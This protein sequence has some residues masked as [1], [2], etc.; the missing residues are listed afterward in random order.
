M[1]K[2]ARWILLVMLLLA[3]GFGFVKYRGRHQPVARWEL[4]DGT[5][6]R[7]E[8]L[9]Y[10][11]KHRIP[12]VG[13]LG[14]WSSQ[15][16]NRWLHLRLP[17]YQAEYRVE[18]T[19]FPCPVLW[20]TLLDPQTGKLSQPNI[21]GVAVLAEPG[22]IRLKSLNG[23]SSS[24]NLPFPC[25]AFRI[26]AY[27]RRAESIRLRLD[28]GGQIIE[29]NITNPARGQSFVEWKPEPLP[30]TR[31]VGTREFTLKELKLFRW[32]EGTQKGLVQ[33]SSTFDI[34]DASG[35]VSGG[36]NVGRDLLD[37]T[38]NMHLEILP[39]DE[40]AWKVRAS[41]RRN[42]DCPFAASEG[43]TLG[44]VEMPGTDA[45]AEFEV[46]VD[47]KKNGIRFAAIVGAG[48]FIWEDGKFLNAEAVAALWDKS[49]GG[50]GPG[51]H[52]RFSQSFSEPGLM[53]LLEGTD[54][55][56]WVKAENHIA[57]R[58]HT[59]GKGY[60]LGSGGGSASTDG[61]GVRRI[62]RVFTAPRDERGNRVPLS[63]PVSIQIVPVEAEVVEFLVAPPKLPESSP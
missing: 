15:M 32:K 35:D 61:N 5:E 14:A 62:K 56:K 17:Y 63:G 58:L 44:P 53:L 50:F 28:M 24:G 43:L 12:G 47:E 18:D 40:P 21:T 4:A 22:A 38:G 46:S 26:A 52:V 45:H 36:F 9:T 33:F 59:G 10:G 51:G 54:A 30:Q 49:L 27:P 19:E 1:G 6:L 2:K 20:F 42:G 7:L 41:F 34:R 31:R 39:M 60:D 37:A 3:A 29:G 55:Q 13:A 8:Y 11:T 48:R 23:N 16:A 57:F 25:A